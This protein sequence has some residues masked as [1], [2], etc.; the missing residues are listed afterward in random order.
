MHCNSAL[1]FLEN[2]IGII[3]DTTQI[4]WG[5]REGCMLSFHMARSA[6]FTCVWGLG[7]VTCLMP[8]NEQI[9]NNKICMFVMFGKHDGPQYDLLATGCKNDKTISCRLAEARN[10]CMHS[11]MRSYTV[12]FFEDN[13][14]GNRNSAVLHLFYDCSS[15]HL[16]EGEKWR[17]KSILFFCIVYLLHLFTFFLVYLFSDH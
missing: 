15:L 3:V 10:C 6:A 7:R 11:T 1:L 8:A 14:L 4:G 16:S 17:E 9:W 5:W 2:T 13:N 12:F